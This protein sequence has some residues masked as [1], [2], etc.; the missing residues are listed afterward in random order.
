[1]YYKYKTMTT[2]EKKEKERIRCRKYYQANKAAILERQ[3]KYD[4]ANKDKKALYDKKYREE[5]SELIR[6]YHAKRYAENPEAYSSGS[7]KDPNYS[8][9]YYKANRDSIL[10]KHKK[11][12]E[13]NKDGFYSVYYLPE[14]N[15]VGQTNCMRVR[16]NDHR[17]KH[18]RYTKD[19]EVLA[20]FET[21]KEALAF[22]AELHKMG[23]NGLN[24]GV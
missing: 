20:K 15:Y 1:M 2:E 11:Y 6:E 9:N 3:K 7:Y 22:E 16:M 10:A 5:N 12:H 24:N 14:E 17:S 23:Y 4:A 13:Y 8:S 21:R 19:V 18:G